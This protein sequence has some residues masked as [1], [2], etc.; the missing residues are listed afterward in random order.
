MAGFASCISSRRN[1][2]SRFEFSFSFSLLAIYYQERKS[3]SVPNELA[4]CVFPSRFQKNCKSRSRIK[5]TIFILD[6]LSNKSVETSIT[7]HHWQPS[8]TN[9]WRIEIRNLIFELLPLVRI[10]NG[11][12]YP[13]EYWKYDFIR[14]TVFLL[15]AFNQ[16]LSLQIAIKINSK[17]LFFVFCIARIKGIGR[18]VGRTRLKSR[19]TSRRKLENCR[20][21]EFLEE[22]RYLF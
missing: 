7:F 3:N 21:I 11:P 1:E 18:N 16:K 19:R 8:I 10:W 12:R 14:I 4:K 22:K 20:R 6:E 17:Y 15:R 9:M 5:I 2:Q 13:M